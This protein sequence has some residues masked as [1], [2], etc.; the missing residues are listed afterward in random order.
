MDIKKKNMV[1]LLLIA[2]GFAMAAVFLNMAS[3]L[4]PWS[5]KLPHLDSAVWL[6]CAVEMKKGK[7]IYRDVWDHKGPVLFAIQILGLSLTPHSLN[8]IWLL[9]C[10]FSFFTLWSFY[11][12]AQLVAEN[13][14]V[15]F[16]ISVFSMHSVYYFYQEGNCVEEWALPFIGFSLYYFA[17]YMK[18]GKCIKIDIIL[19]GVLMC[20][21][22]LL[23]G[24]L[25]AVWVCYILIISVKIVWNRQFQEFGQCVLFFVIGFFS[26]LAVVLLV[27]A[28]QGALG[29]F[30]NIYFGFNYD[31]ISGATFIQ[32]KYSVLNF[33]FK[34]NWFVFS[35]MILFFLLF[36][37][38]KPDWTWSAFFYTIIS[39]IFISI[40]G[41]EYI[42]YGLQLVPCMVIPMAVC[43]NRVWKWCRSYKEFLLIVAVAGLVWIRFEVLHYEELIHWTV[44]KEGD[45]YF[46]GGDLENYTIVNEWIG[47]RWSKEALEKWVVNDH[48]N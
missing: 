36:H 46:A 2:V 30:L 45:N 14:F 39:L 5:H 34:D 24:N 33:A 42:H 11:L 8:G 20:C 16:L 7:V 41:R 31:Y 26:M 47:N 43:M 38:W 18:T 35:H 17:K 27:L 3:T 4:N 37:D 28:F 22:F 44:S 48:A 12:T 29:S 32:F 9:E 1:G 6:R 21:S 40:S 23:N 25:I 10:V 15:S 13:K 19:T